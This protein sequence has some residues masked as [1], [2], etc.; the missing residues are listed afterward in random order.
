MR[1]LEN[2]KKYQISKGNQKV[3]VAGQVI[4]CSGTSGPGG[5]GPTIGGGSSGSSTCQSRCRDACQF[6]PW[7]SAA[8]ENECTALC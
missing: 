1:K 4:G 2:L 5:S 8:C 3:V 6:D 7:D